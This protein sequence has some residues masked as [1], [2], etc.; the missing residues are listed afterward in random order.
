[1][2]LISFYG[3]HT[4]R[5]RPSRVFVG[6]SLII[7]VLESNKCGYKRITYKF[8]IICSND[9]ANLSVSARHTL[10]LP[11]TLSRVLDKSR[12]LVTD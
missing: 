1:M 10:R 5:L 2:L 7:V 6:W 11:V 3:R 9:I 12:W 8:L 4:H